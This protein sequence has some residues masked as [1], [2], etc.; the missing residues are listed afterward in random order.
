MW[1]SIISVEAMIFYVEFISGG[2][3]PGKNSQYQ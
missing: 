1:V 2:Q 3:E